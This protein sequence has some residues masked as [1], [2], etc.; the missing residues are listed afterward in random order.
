M[1][2][3]PRVDVV[4]IPCHVLNRANRRAQMFM[5]HGDYAAFERL[6]E[7]AKKQAPVALYAYCLMPN[8]WHLVAAP[9]S[10]GALSVFIQWL[11]HTH[12]KRWNTAHDATGTGHLYQ[13]RFKSFPIQTDEHFLTVCRY[14]ERNALRAN[15]V[16]RAEHW[17]WSSAWRRQFGSDEQSGILD[18]WPVPRSNDYL[19]WLNTPHTADELQAI[20][21]S[22]Q[23]GKPYGAPE[24]TGHIAGQFGISV[25][26]RGRPRKKMV[27]GTIFWHV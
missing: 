14:V 1:A 9:Y 17:R 20:R 21:S 10:D 22:I 5:T 7:E 23:R 16:E 24:W 4:N 13:D 19:E 8:H 27:P 12:A 2:R 18:A 6:L 11:T 15:L 3:S 26:Q 25:R